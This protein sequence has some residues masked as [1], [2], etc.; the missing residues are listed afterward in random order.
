MDEVEKETVIRGRRKREVK[1]HGRNK[2][3]RCSGGRGK[4][5]E[6]E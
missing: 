4:E 3:R 6:R 5:K 2:K 1:N